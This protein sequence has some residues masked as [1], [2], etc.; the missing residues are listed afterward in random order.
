[1][2]ASG[3]RLEPFSSVAEVRDRSRL[4]DLLG[5]GVGVVGE[6]ILEL[7]DASD[8]DIFLVPSRSDIT[9]SRGR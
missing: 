7:S 6:M 5:D 1:L 3:A 4:A 2:S 9:A 8:F